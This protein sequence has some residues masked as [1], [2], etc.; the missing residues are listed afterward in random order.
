M[1]AQSATGSSLMILIAHP[2]GEENWSRFV[3]RYGPRVMALYRFM[4]LQDADAQDACQETLQKLVLKISTF[5][6]V[7]GSFRSW[8]KGVAKNAAIDV[9]RQGKRVRGVGGDDSDASLAATIEDAWA[10]AQL[11]ELIEFEVCEEALSRARARASDG[12]WQAFELKELKGLDTTVAAQRLGISRANIY[13]R[14]S[15]VRKLVQEELD[16]LNGNSTGDQ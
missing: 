6:P 14:V 2:S 12:D 9:L 13:M 10:R 15:R 4:Q 1:S 16:R 3:Q 7:E 11:D 8:L 5:D